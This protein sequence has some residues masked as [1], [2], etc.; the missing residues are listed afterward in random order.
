MGSFLRKHWRLAVFIALVVL[1]TV[2]YRASG[3]QHDLNLKGIDH[4]RAHALA[5]GWKGM[6]VYSAV[7]V[8][9]L[10]VGMPNLPFQLAAGAIYGIWRAYVMMYI[11]VNLGALAAFAVARYLGRRSVEQ[12][13]GQKLT[14]LNRAIERKGNRYLLVLRLIPLV[15]FNAVNF[16]SGLSRMPFSLYAAATAIGTL[17]LTLVHVVAG[18]VMGRIF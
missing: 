16:A 5:Y 10:A 6:A 2:S 3:L 13:A 11:S 4:L 15:P 12:L 7:Y 8:L 14:D 1:G 17:P 9:C 18:H